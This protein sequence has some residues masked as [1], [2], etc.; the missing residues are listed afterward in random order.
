MATEYENRKFV[1]Q[2]LIDARNIINDAMYY[3]T[4]NIKNKQK[5]IAR[6][7]KIRQSIIKLYNSII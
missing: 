3:H 2:S 1:R 7:K 4:D 6:L 5:L